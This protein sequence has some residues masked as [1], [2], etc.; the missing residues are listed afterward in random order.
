MGLAA[1]C[2]CRNERRITCA[3]EVPEKHGLLVH[4]AL[5]GARKRCYSLHIVA[6]PYQVKKEPVFIG[7][8]CNFL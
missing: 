6:S 7:K 4:T 1:E 5:H 8:G 2:V 3:Q